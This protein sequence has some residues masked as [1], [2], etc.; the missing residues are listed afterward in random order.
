MNGYVSFM[1]VHGPPSTILRVTETEMSIRTS[2]LPFLTVHLLLIPAPEQ[3]IPSFHKRTYNSLLHHS[4]CCPFI[5]NYLQMLHFPG[6]VHNIT[7]FHIKVQEVHI[8]TYTYTMVF[9]SSK[10][11]TESGAP[12]DFLMVGVEL[13]LLYDY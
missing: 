6:C 12:L 2:N 8:Y 3:G 5:R 13:G 7:L 11:V 4:S 1:H 10:F 9:S